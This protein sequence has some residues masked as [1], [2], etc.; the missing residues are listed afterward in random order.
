[1]RA[2]LAL[3]RLMSPQILRLLSSLAM[4]FGLCIKPLHGCR[5][6]EWMMRFVVR[7]F[8]RQEMNGFAL[9]MFFLACSICWTWEMRAM[10]SL[11]FCCCSFCC[12]TMLTNP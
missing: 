6:L 1:M 9:Q 5:G 10:A 12:S 7:Y 2:L 4:T 8:P 3:K 11:I